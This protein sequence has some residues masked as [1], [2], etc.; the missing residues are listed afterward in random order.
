MFTL[1]LRVLFRA[2]RLGLGLGG[3]RNSKKFC[4]NLRNFTLCKARALLTILCHPSYSINVYSHNL[5]Y[6]VSIA[7]YRAQFPETFKEAL[8]QESDGKEVFGGVAIGLAAAFVFFVF[9][10]KY[11]K[12]YFIL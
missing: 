3:F 1:L 11:G 7:V 4:T 2:E 12:Y 9:L 6:I 5:Q 8:T 10:K